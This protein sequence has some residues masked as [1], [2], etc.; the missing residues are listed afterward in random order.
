MIFALWLVT[1]LLLGIWTLMAGIAAATLSWLIAQAPLAADWAAQVANLPLPP[2]LSIWMD[3]VLAEW[4]RQLVAQSLEGLSVVLPWLQP[5]L[6]WLVP[7]TWVVWGL[8]LVA[9]LGMAALGHWALRRWQHR[10]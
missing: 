8:G 3:P 2:W 7:L 9:L 4:T 6:G 1:F 10:T 5:M